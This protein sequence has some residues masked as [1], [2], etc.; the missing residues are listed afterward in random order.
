MHALSVKRV[1]RYDIVGS[2]RCFSALTFPMDV[3]T[4]PAVSFRNCAFRIHAPSLRAQSWL[5]ARSARR[6]SPRLG[7]RMETGRELIARVA[8]PLGPVSEVGL[9]KV[10]PLLTDCFSTQASAV[11]LSSQATGHKRIRTFS[12]TPRW[13]PRRA[14]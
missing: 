11:C 13:V 1:L 9:P 6:A 7:L 12:M 4:Y 10:C 8:G 3:R 5:A 14:G 2:P